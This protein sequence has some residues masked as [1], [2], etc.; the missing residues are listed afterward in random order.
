MVEK[1]IT[2]SN[3][4]LQVEESN[5]S[6]P[7]ESDQII[8]ELESQ[9][10]Q[11]KQQLVKYESKK[12]QEEEQKII[13]PKD[14]L[15]HIQLQIKR[16]Q[17]ESLLEKQVEYKH[18]S[19][20]LPHVVS[21]IEEPVTRMTS[22]LEQLISTIQDPEV[23]D[24]L[25]QCKNMALSMVQGVKKI[26]DNSDKL[27]QDV[28]PVKRAVDILTF[29][30][31][32]ARKRNSEGQQ[33]KLFAPSKFMSQ[34]YLDED[35]FKKAMLILLKE[36][37][38][39]SPED[40]IKITLKQG[41]KKLFDINLQELQVSL[42]G[43]TDWELEDN[44]MQDYLEQTLNNSEEVGLDLLYAKKIIEQHKGSLEFHKE[45]GQV[46]GFDVALPLMEK[47]N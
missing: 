33:I 45:Q 17:I 32:L 2:K 3:L 7:D 21:K 28:E 30:K 9:L 29:F 13:P 46:I 10:N 43:E 5:K 20:L 36:I 1:I 26:H 27:D 31:S 37:A 15:L 23:C 47:P 11:L 4:S 44:E 12:H 42:A 18:R 40:T 35:M 24:T 38:R 6:L 22:N 41:N 14:D 8:S 34:S 19:N 25:R 39:I 16:E